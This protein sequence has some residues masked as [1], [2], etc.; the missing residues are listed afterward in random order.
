M[1]HDNEIPEFLGW[2]IVEVLYPK[3]VGVPE[4]ERVYDGIGGFLEQGE[5]FAVIHHATG[6]LDAESRRYIATR[7]TKQSARSQLYMKAEAVVTMS[8]IIRG[9]VIALGWIYP[10]PHPIRTF[11][12]RAEA[13][14]WCEQKLAEAAPIA[15]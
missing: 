7:Q 4:L 14:A 5:D 8:A 12:T 1:H 6:I 3:Q 11:A 15:I 9:V 2:P 10:H 13:L